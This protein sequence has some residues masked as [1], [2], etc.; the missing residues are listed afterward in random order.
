M[1]NDA[2]K[3]VFEMPQIAKGWAALK[4]IG[5]NKEVLSANFN[6]YYQGRRH[7]D[8]LLQPRLAF[9]EMGR[10]TSSTTH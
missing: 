4:K 3:L 8:P 2:V 6:G 10:S 9:L 1:I 7:S 5:M